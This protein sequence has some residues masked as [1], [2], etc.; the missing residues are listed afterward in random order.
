MIFVA[1]ILPTFVFVELFMRLK[2]L[3]RAAVPA[4]LAQRS[5]RIIQA[6]RISD[7]WKERVLPVYSGR[8]MLATVRLLLVLLVAFSPFFIAAFA[9][10]FTELP[11]L[12]EMTSLRGILISTVAAFIYVFVRKRLVER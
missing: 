2:V 4:Q 1:L 10:S 5:L 3:K 11:L 12:E 8:M 9:A 7:H 6:E